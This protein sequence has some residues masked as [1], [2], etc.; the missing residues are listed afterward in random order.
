VIKV[1]EN[2]WIPVLDEQFLRSLSW[3]RAG[4]PKMKIRRISI[5]D[6]TTVSIQGAVMDSTS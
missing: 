4:L 6:I 5:T 2:Q 1:E 3:M